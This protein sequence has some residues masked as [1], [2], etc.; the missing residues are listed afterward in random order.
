M[1]VSPV[2]WMVFVNG[3]IPSF[4]SWIFWLGVAPRLRKPPFRD[5]GAIFRMNHHRYLLMILL[6]IYLWYVQKNEKDMIFVMIQTQFSHSDTTYSPV[7]VNYSLH[8]WSSTNSDL[9]RWVHGYP[10]CDD[11]HFPRMEDH[12]R[13]SFLNG[14]SNHSELVLSHLW[15]G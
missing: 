14:E 10:N 5:I 12:P 2:P 1:G 8:H 15:M 13:S 9:L 4:D 3:K 7:F 6:W 11:S